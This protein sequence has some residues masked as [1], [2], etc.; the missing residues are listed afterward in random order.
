[1]MISGVTYLAEPAG[2]RWNPERTVWQLR[3]DRV[4]ALGLK[5][6]IVD[7]PASNTGCPGSRGEHLH[8][9]ARAASR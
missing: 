6:R 7:E 5:T 9:D 2:R 4:L 1:M 8:A 3:Y